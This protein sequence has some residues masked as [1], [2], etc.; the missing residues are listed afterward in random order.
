MAHRWQTTGDAYGPAPQEHQVVYTTLHFEQPWSFENYLKIGGYKR[1]EE[2]PREKTRPGDVI[3]M[4]KQSGLR[5]RGG[6][7]FPTGLKWSFMP[8]G[9][10]AEIHPLQLGRIRAG[11]VPR[12]ATSCA[13]TRIR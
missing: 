8:Q 10:R 9:R 7:G 6:A 3:E 2:D 12:T 5:G 1:V 13:S 11:H 4:V